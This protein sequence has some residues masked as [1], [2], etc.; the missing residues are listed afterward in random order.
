MLAAV[1]DSKSTSLGTL[2]TEIVLRGGLLKGPVVLAGLSVVLG[3]QFV[4]L[5][6]AD[7]VLNEFLTGRPAHLRLLAKTSIFEKLL[8]LRNGRCRDLLAEIRQPAGDD[9]GVMVAGAEGQKDDLG[10]DD[11]G[12][13]LVAENHVAQR[14]RSV[15]HRVLKSQLHRTAVVSQEQPD[16]TLWKPVL[17]VDVA[18]KAPAMEC[19]AANFQALFDIVQA[20]LADGTSHR[21]RY[22]SDCPLP[23][24]KAPRHYGD[25]SSEYWVRGRWVRRYKLAS[26]TRPVIH[27]KYRTLKRKP[28]D[29]AAAADSKKARGR[30]RGRKTASVVA[31]VEAAAGGDAELDL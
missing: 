28:S 13:V 30:G 3:K 20:D 4:A 18:H 7:K 8:A 5:R 26:D 9:A 2:P 1:D 6:K 14:A 22:G 24:A 29:E 23:A 16:G 17:L 15:S 27:R 10:L 21:K 25:G 19:V 11:P 12:D 31:N